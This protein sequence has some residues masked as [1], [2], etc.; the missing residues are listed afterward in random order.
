MTRPLLPPYNEVTAPQKVRAAEGA[1]N[2]RDPATVVLACTADC[3][4]RR[5]KSVQ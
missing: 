2:A 3:R 4:W 5:D 1:W